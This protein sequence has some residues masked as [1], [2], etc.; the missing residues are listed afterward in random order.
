MSNLSRKSAIGLKVPKL[1]NYFLYV[2]ICLS[3]VYLTGCSTPPAW[4]R[5]RGDNNNSGSSDNL[6]PG[7]KIIWTNSQG[8]YRS[9]AV[10]GNKGSL[11]YFNGINNQIIQADAKTGVTLHAFSG[12]AEFASPPV[13]SDTYVIAGCEDGKVY[14]LNASDLSLR[15]A[16]AVS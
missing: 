1:H 11:V 4:I 6:L 8:S 3:L 10:F 2:I 7:T 13:I 9:T 5:L 12:G 16:T 15:W 14:T